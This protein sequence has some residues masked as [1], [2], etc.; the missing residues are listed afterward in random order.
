MWS[1]RAERRPGARER[2]LASYSAVANVEQA[3]QSLK[4][5]GRAGVVAR[6][7]RGDSKG[8]NKQ[9]PRAARNEKARAR[10]RRAPATPAP[11]HAAAADPAGHAHHEQVV[12]VR[13]R[14]P[15]R[16]GAAA[17]S[18]KNASDRG[19]ALP[20]AACPALPAASGRR[21]VDRRGEELEPLCTEDIRAATR[22][23]GHRDSN[24][25]NRDRR[26]S[27]GAPSGC[28]RSSSC[29]PPREAE[30]A[31]PVASQRP[32]HFETRAE[33]MGRD[34]IYPRGVDLMPGA[35]VDVPR[36]WRRPPRH[37][38]AGRPCTVDSIGGIS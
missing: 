16:C 26:G 9:R 12:F 19:A 2:D 27:H 25:P 38:R 8:V 18:G 5:P 13:G 37:P 29:A 17:A 24:S 15:L 31:P 1:V 34:P 4:P 14:K 30:G 32:G 20:A 28:F 21:T 22:L 33:R 10:A 7:G 36:S 6:P 23:Y 35:A 3:R 11:D